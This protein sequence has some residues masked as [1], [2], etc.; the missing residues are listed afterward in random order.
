M[1]NDVAFVK[2]IQI[3]SSDLFISAV[4]KPGSSF[5]KYMLSL[6]MDFG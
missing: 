4:K 2:C 6:R 1:K 3:S 5:G